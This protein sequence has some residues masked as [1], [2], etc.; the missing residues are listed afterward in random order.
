MVNHDEVHVLFQ[1]IDHQLQE[2]ILHHFLH[3]SFFMKSFIHTKLF[4]GNFWET[5]QP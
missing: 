4:T 2:N 5:A 3:F 1:D